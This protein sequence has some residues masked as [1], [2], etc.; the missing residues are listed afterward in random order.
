MK[1]VLRNLIYATGL[2]LAFAGCT[3]GP[4]QEEEISINPNRRNDLNTRSIILVADTSPSMEDLA[5]GKEKS[6]APRLHLRTLL[7]SARHIMQLTK[8]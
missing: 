7:M 2:G 3:Y 5:M 1:S 6:T 4:P 8:I